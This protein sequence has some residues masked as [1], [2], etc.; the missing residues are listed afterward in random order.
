[1]DI[2]LVEKADVVVVEFGDEFQLPGAAVELLC[3]LPDLGAGAGGEKRI[4]P[5][6]QTAGTE[7]VVVKELQRDEVVIVGIPV[8]GMEQGEDDLGGAGLPGIV[9]GIQRVAGEQLEAVGKEQP[10]LVPLQLQLLRPGVVQGREVLVI[11]G[12]TIFPSIMIHGLCIPFFHRKEDR[13]PADSDYTRE[14]RKI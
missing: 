10:Q 7:P 12:R 13:L 9:I 11:V 2:A 3:Q 8:G 1:M 5:P 4:G 6:E 14:F